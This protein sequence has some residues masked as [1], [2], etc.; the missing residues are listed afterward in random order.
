[1][2][3]GTSRVRAT[4]DLPRKASR[5]GSNRPG[6]DTEGMTSMCAENNAV[7]PRHLDLAERFWSKVDQS[8]DCWIWLG[9]KSSSGYGAFAP[10]FKERYVAHRFSY[11]LVVGPIPANCDMDHLCRNP[12]C[13][14]PAH[15]EPVSHAEN[16][17]RGMGFSG[18]NA[19][20]VQCDAGHDL[21]GDNLYLDPKGRRQCKTCRNRAG[22]EHR[23][24][25]GAGQAAAEREARNAE[26]A[27]RYEAGERVADLMAEYGVA[28]QQI[29]R[30]AV[31]G[32]A[33]R[34]TRS[35]AQY[36]RHAWARVEETA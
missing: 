8:G 36:M 16:C 25:H 28:R 31:S 15:L 3:A 26:V 5:R 12:P 29:I 21:D 33:R 11:E 2:S 19:R 18:R 27:R 34:R 1:M 23:A 24:R 30:W 6:H 10:A 7:P 13:V 17:R 9:G 14:N 4:I 20:K 32:G 35:E 22:R